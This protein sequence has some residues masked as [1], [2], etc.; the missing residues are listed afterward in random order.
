MCFFAG[1][2]VKCGF[3]IRAHSMNMKGILH[4]KFLSWFFFFF[5]FLQALSKP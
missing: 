4:Q 5:F 1:E 3:E 2:A